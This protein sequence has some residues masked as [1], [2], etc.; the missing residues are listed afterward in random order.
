MK[1]SYH[2]HLILL[3][4]MQQTLRADLRRQL[5][6]FYPRRLQALS[7]SNPHVHSPPL[8]G[9]A[10]QNKDLRLCFFMM[11][12]FFYYSEFHHLG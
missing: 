4:D 12:I 1:T 10:M 6:T 2:V 9:R 8:A 11:Y 5:R 3:I 7:M